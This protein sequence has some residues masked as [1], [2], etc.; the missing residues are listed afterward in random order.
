MEMVLLVAEH[1]RCDEIRKLLCLGGYAF[2]RAEN[3]K[4]A[5]M[6]ILDL[7]L[8]LVIVDAMLPGSTA[9]N[10]S[11]FAAS[12]DVD[13]V[14]IVPDEL[15]SHVA[16]VM[17]KYGVYVGAANRDSLAA[18]LNA[19][20]VAR[21]KIRKADE[22]NRKLLDRLR[23]EKLLTEAKCLLAG[24]RGMSEEEAHCYIERKAMDCRI[25]LADAAMSIVRELS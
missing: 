21:E 16:L 23:N 8:S 20:S 11:V 14:L 15:A 12:Q 19:I 18:V 3:E 1:S 2:I 10:V 22:R 7:Q 13:T 5:R 6:K 25:S 4:E 24:R 9:K 17:R